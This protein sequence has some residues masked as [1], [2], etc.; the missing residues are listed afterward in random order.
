[1]PLSLNNGLTGSNH[2]GLN[3]VSDCKP[4]FVVYAVLYMSFGIAMTEVKKMHKKQLCCE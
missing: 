2:N 4:D 3:V 1:M